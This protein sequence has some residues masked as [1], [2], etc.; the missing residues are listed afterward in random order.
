MVFPGDAT[1]CPRDVVALQLRLPTFWCHNPQ[2]WFAQVEAT[3]DLHH[4]TSETSPFRHLLCDLSPE[5][6]QEVADVIAAP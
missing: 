4:I 6:A 5:V 2:V 3:F 1:S